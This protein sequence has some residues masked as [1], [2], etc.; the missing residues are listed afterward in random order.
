MTT[1]NVLEMIF[2]YQ[3]LNAKQDH[4]GVSLD[5]DERARLY[6]LGRLLTGDG[7]S[8]VRTM[9]RLPYPKAVSCTT[10]GGFA[11]GE[12]PLA[13]LWLVVLKGNAQLN[14]G[15]RQ[16]ALQ[17]P[18]GPATFSW[19]NRGP[20]QPGPAPLQGPPRACEWWGAAGPLFSGRRGCRGPTCSRRRRPAGRRPPRR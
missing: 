12:G 6:G 13:F 8:G 16:F 1:R 20:A 14:T 11:T 7:P 15:A 17:A 10:P 19:A 3:L 5:D 9:P 4:L 18:P 2:E